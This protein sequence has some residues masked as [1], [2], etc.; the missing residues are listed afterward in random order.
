MLSPESLVS[1]SDTSI[2]SVIKQSTVVE[3][4]PHVFE[5]MPIVSKIFKEKVNQY[6]L[7]GSRL[8]TEELNFQNGA[9]ILK[10][11][12][13][14]QTAWHVIPTFDN[15]ICIVEAAQEAKE[16]QQSLEAI[17]ISCN[18]FCQLSVGIV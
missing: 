14:C 5:Q 10:V 17:F 7:V 12:A 11:R 9:K 6:R 13:D 3:A 18:R 8:V 4:L 1:A 2:P 15:D 16:H